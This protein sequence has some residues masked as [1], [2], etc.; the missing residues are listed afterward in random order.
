MPTLSIVHNYNTPKAFAGRHVEKGPDYSKLMDLTQGLNLGFVSARRHFTIPSHFLEGLEPI[1]FDVMCADRTAIKTALV[2]SDRYFL[3][4]KYF[5]ESVSLS[6]QGYIIVEDPG[7]KQAQELEVFLAGIA[8]HYGQSHILLKHYAMDCPELVCVCGQHCTTGERNAL[9]A[10]KSE[11][12]VSTV[13]SW[14]S[15]QPQLTEVDLVKAERDE[16]APCCG[17]QDAEFDGLLQDVLD[18]TVD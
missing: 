10:W 14:V 13:E 17:N 12:L 5:D 6:H 7:E 2:N 9:P 1:L 11:T 8:R 4:I 3:P 18:T 15:I 16:F